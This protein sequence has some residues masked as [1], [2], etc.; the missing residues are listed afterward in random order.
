M[1]AAHLH[2]LG[3]GVLWKIPE[4]LV[5][6]KMATLWKPRVWALEPGLDQACPLLAS[7]PRQGGP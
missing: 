7:D 6:G 4:E 2:A 1:L 3:L 5:Q